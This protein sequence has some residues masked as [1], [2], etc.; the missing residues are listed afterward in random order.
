MINPT[1]TDGSV[2]LTPTATSIESPRCCN[3]LRRGAHG[4]AH[5]FWLESTKSTKLADSQKSCLNNYK[6]WIFI[7]NISVIFF[8]YFCGSGYLWEFFFCFLS[9]GHP[10]LVRDS[11]QTE[12]L[13][14]HFATYFWS[15]SLDINSIHLCLPLQMVARHG[16]MQLK[17]WQFF[18]SLCLFFLLCFWVQS[19]FGI[20]RNG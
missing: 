2:L 8:S 6:Y 3:P 1:A 7:Q 10:C 13:P 5:T 15:E 12:S 20:M 4:R 19:N 16:L 9:G 17:V 18:P 14:Y 11:S